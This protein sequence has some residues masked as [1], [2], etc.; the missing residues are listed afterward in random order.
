MSGEA[1]VP[2]L[3]PASDHS[4]L[5]RFGDEIALEAHRQVLRLTTALLEQPAPF[6]RNLHPA[7]ASVLVS[8]DPRAASPAAV[9][10]YL[11]KLLQE[12]PEVELPPSRTVE[13][14]VCYEPPFAPDLEEVASLHGL[15]AA[16]VIALH[17]QAEYRVYFLGF[18]PGFPYMGGLPAQLVTP[19]LATP[20]TRVPAGSV[21]IGG[22]QT[23]VYPLA[24][25]G[26]WR[27]IG[28]TPLPLF[29]PEASPPALLQMGDL[30]RFVSVSREAYEAFAG[31]SGIDGQKDDLL[32]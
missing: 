7:Y 8:F 28:R 24:S 25:P 6:I 31:E 19:R 14:P 12:L 20:R 27:L 4:V 23:G 22:A 9:Q 32:R 16:E 26:G 29:R 5:V 18:S 10:D 2:A 30:V 15:S 11:A 21:A 1:P 13:I 3:V 17:T